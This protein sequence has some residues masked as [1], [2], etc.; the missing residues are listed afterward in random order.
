MA[1]RVRM[2]PSCWPPLTPSEKCWFPA[3]THWTPLPAITQSS[4]DN[5][6]LIFIPIAASLQSGFIL[7]CLYPHGFF[8]F[9]FTLL[10]EHKLHP[11]LN[12]I[13]QMALFLKTLQ[14][15]LWLACQKFFCK[16]F[17]ASCAK[18]TCSPTI[19]LIL[20]PALC[21]HGTMS[22]A[23]LLPRSQPSKPTGRTLCALQFS[24]L[25]LHTHF[26]DSLNSLYKAFSPF[27]LRIPVYKCLLQNPASSPLGPEYLHRVCLCVSGQTFA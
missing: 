3:P 26:P 6:S 19:P 18:G 17:S 16:R 13:T 2:G 1:V 7:T 4:H 14:R 22:L 9:Q 27:F 8:S 21:A 10:T 5:V 15:H 11:F 25:S 12:I 23:L 20:L 24:K